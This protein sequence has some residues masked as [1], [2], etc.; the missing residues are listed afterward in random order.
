MQSLL[1][2]NTTVQASAGSGKTY[3]LVSRIIQLLLLGAEPASILAITF[4]RKAAAEM[5]QRLLDRLYELAAADDA[6][7]KQLLEALDIP[8][9]EQYQ[10]KARQ[11]YEDLLCA[12]QNIKATTFH[13]F[14]QDLLRRFPLEANVPAGFDLLERTAST[15]DEAWEALMSEA[16]T[17]SQSPVAKA[18][19]FLFRE[20][21]TYN[22]RQSL[23]SFL[24][25]RSDWW[26]YTRDHADPVS[27]ASDHLAEQ[28][29]VDVDADP[30]AVFL[31][32]NKDL[33]RFVYFLEKHVT[34]T[35]TDMAESLTQGLS[36]L[37]DASTSFKKICSVFMTGN[38]EPRKRKPSKA[39]SK[40]YGED[41][42]NEFL[43]LHESICARI[44]ATNE[45]RNAIKTYQLSCAWY[46]AGHQLIQHY[47]RIK[48]EQRLL[49]FTDL[50]WK[51]FLLLT[52]SEHALWVQYKLDT[53]I[54]HLLIDEFQDTNP[55]QWQLVLPILEEMA[56]SQSDRQR[57]VF[58]VGDAKQSIYR[59]RRAEPRLFN[60]AQSWLA[61]KMQ[62]KTLP[63]N[64]SWRSSPAIIDFVN[65]LFG[66]GDLHEQLPDFSPHATQHTELSG[67]VKLLGLGVDDEADEEEIPTAGLRNPLTTPREQNI[68]QAHYKEGQLIANE[69]N[70]LVNDRVMIEADGASRPVTYSDII[71]LLRART[72][73]H[74]YEQALREQG[75]PY[76]GA[77]RGTLLDALEVIDM[78][79][80][81][82]WLITPFD[83]LALAGILRSPVFDLSNDDLKMIANAGSGN[84]YERLASLAEQQSDSDFNRAYVMLGRW[85]SRAGH[86]P[87]HDLLD[88]IYSEANIL[89]RYQ[90]AFPLELKPRVSANLTRFLELALEMDSGRYPSLTR[91]IQWLTELQ[92]QST[93][94]PDEPPAAIRQERV[95]LLTIHESKGLEAPIVFLVDSASTPSNNSAHQS[96]I[97]WPAESD[98]PECFLMNRPKKEC[99]AFGRAQLEHRQA[100]ETQ[101]EANLL[102]VAVT[103]ARQ[104][105]Y[106]SGTQSARGSQL[107]WYGQVLSAY[108]VDGEGL[109]QDRTLENFGQI[110][111]STSVEKIQT[112]KNLNIDKNLSQA[113]N[114]KSFSGEIAPSYSASDISSSSTDTDED[115]RKRGIAIHLLLEKLSDK[116]LTPEQ[117]RQLTQQQLSG[118]L[119]EDEFNDCWQEATGLISDNN[120]GFLFDSNKYKQAYNEV[121]VCYQS[122]NKTVN[123]IIDRLVISEDKIV[124]VDYKTHQQSSE[125]EL[126][127]LTQHYQPQM[128]YYIEGIEKLWP[129]ASIQ[130][131][132]LFTHSK[133]IRA[134]ST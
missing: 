103:R 90:A 131:M 4:T 82:N 81:L 112:E 25:H 99:E 91:F 117:A 27:Y 46:R 87:A 119:S 13:A 125:V 35:N 11:L 79:N 6:Q 116:N 60:T 34:K 126:D 16:A 19:D 15:Q 61:E 53:R 38:N 29:Q 56:A 48:Q 62:A 5:Q 70:T 67:Q 66:Q 80:L 22:T 134:I 58:L 115:G 64:K 3:L 83:N 121:P 37:F 54:D 100:Q 33:H 9:D 52:Q 106:I 10:H 28:M 95:R 101:E 20:L 68:R 43:Q 129:D 97:N 23:L 71:V 92:Q 8:A 127:K 32:D 40:S 104:Y 108:E 72:H 102:Y 75:I 26:A 98:R 105:L 2:E 17:Q 39:I 114:I 89:A 49:D 31:Q 47:Q 30:L 88:Q 36:N 109:D 110:N 133:T 55:T 12:A 120:L 77:D 65:R 94:S 45:Q 57:S 7:L 51:T 1:C 41:G 74:D 93:E 123:G 63:L 42:A 50:E 14:C 21:A 122:G 24:N 85:R 111:K 86:I 18:I 96:L 113:I 76:L 44:I 128:R 69:I 59:F 130:A 84:W 124:I 107:G 73:V 118:S 78:V 132:I